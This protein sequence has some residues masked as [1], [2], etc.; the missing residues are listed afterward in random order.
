MTGRSGSSGWAR[1]DV[2]VVVAL[3]VFVLMLGGPLTS[4]PRNQAMRVVCRANLSQIGKAMLLYADDYD[5]VLPRAADPNAVWNGPVIWN[6]SNWETAF[7]IPSDGKGG[8][9]TISSCFYLLVKYLQVSPKL[10]VCPSDK[11]TEEFKLADEIVYRADFKLADAWDFGASPAENCSYAYHIPFG[12]HRLTTSRDPNLAVAAD[13]NPWITS[14]AAYPGDFSLFQP[15]VSPYN[16][17]LRMARN[18]NAI[19]H[20]MDGQNVLFLDGRVTFEHRSFCGLDDDNIYTVASS[21]VRGDAKGCM[22]VYSPGLQPRNQRDSLLVHDPP[23]FA[24]SSQA[25]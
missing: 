17:T 13:R 16:G 4:M 25:K 8:G 9:A 10:F 20:Q 12:E 23:M 24:R 2:L 5:G 7:Q 14:P 11:G 19:S 22:A 1:T 21:Y 15:D 18:G 3:G 6:A